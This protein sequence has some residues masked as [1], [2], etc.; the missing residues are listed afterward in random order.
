MPARRRQSAAGTHIEG[1]VD[2]C[3]IH[4]SVID[5]GVGLSTDGL[6]IFKLFVQDKN[7]A[8]GSGVGLALV[9]TTLARLGGQISYERNDPF[10]LTFRFGIPTSSSGHP[11]GDSV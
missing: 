11:G 5:N 7:S 1:F 2:D 6:D 8:R 10:G 3:E 4:F 9:K